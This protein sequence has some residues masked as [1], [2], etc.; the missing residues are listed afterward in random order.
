MS[1]SD[2]LLNSSSSL[3]SRL[4]N[5]ANRVNARL[6]GGKDE[7]SVAVEKAA[8]DIPGPVK[9]KHIQHL[10]DTILESKHPHTAS[11]IDDIMLKF[12]ALTIWSESSVVA[13]KV[14]VCLDILIQ[15]C[16]PS[17]QK[18]LESTVLML[19]E[20]QLGWIGKSI[21]IERYVRSLQS[22]VSMIENH[23]LV[24][25]IVFLHNM[26]SLSQITEFL[27]HRDKAI[28][29]SEIVKFIT[30]AL[31]VQNERLAVLRTSLDELPSAEHETFTEANKLTF[32]NCQAMTF[33]ISCLINYISQRDNGEHFN[34]DLLRDQLE[35]HEHELRRRD[36]TQDSRYDD[37]QL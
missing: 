3:R 4:G 9:Q 23:E 34:V 22:K 16:Y 21:Y 6:I 12:N 14:L 31:A 18:H 29:L 36:R 13:C 30:L 32:N 20:I 7:V 25:D 19:R 8:N 37:N 1:S 5:F 17:F 10:I 24:S 27:N 11:V 26:I 28:D 15:K 35:N 33:N 2:T